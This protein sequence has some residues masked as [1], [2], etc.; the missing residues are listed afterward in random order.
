[1]TTQEIANRYYELAQRGAIQT[2]QDELYAPYAV[3][4]EP[5]NDSQLPLKVDGLEALREKEQRYYQNM[6][7]EMHGGSIDTP[8]VSPAHFACVQRMDVTLKGRGRK[9]KV[10][11]GVFTVDQ[12]KIVSEQFFYDDFN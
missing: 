9:Q 8:I 6:V 12:G 11:L 1:M 4:I 7:E 10:Q 5:E 3:S 2:I